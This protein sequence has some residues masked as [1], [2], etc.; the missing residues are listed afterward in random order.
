MRHPR[1]ELPDWRSLSSGKPA[2]LHSP[3][4]DR[5]MAKEL[6][7]LQ[8]RDDGLFFSSSLLA[9]WDL[10]GY[11]SRRRTQL[12]Y[13]Q[14]LY[15]VGKAGIDRAKAANC[16][17][18][19]FRHH[20]LAHVAHQFQ[21]HAQASGKVILVTDGWC[22]LCGRP[23]PLP[24]YLRLLAPYDGL[25]VVDDTQALGILGRRGGGILPYLGLEKTPNVLLVSSLAKAFGVPVA[26][27]S[28]GQ[29]W[30]KRFRAQSEARQFS[31]PPS[32]VEMLA[33]AAALK[34]NRRSG[35]RL[36]DQ[37]RTN[38]LTFQS[39][40]HQVGLSTGGACFPVQHL[41]F[42]DL[43]RIKA[44]H[45]QLLQYGIQA[46][47]VRAHKKGRWALSFLISTEH[48][49]PELLAVARALANSPFLK[50]SDHDQHT[51]GLF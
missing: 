41:W 5:R 48:K 18:Y 49:R 34:L 12:F 22:P 35:D 44:Q 38:I 8:G 32:Q 50:K 39:G 47:P 7:H 6:A 45:R 13:D 11:L 4:A 37:L 9:F 28:G 14:A 19:A 42:D 16:P 24:A 51:A 26:F 3:P 31:S 10:F 36:R 40:L 33:T 46:V 17:V 15:P 30:I 25:L 20:D 29:E 1:A 23:A 2:F 43:H 27:I 21:H